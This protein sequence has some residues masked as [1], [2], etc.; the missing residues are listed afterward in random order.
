MTPVP[1][2]LF[3]RRPDPIAAEGP[4]EQGARR[5][6]AEVLLPGQLS[7]QRAGRSGR[8][9]SG[10]GELGGGR[11]AGRHSAGGRL[12]RAD[13]GRAVDA[14]RG[15]AV[16]GD[17]RR[18]CDALR[19]AAGAVGAGRSDLRDAP[20]TARGTRRRAA[21]EAARQQAGR[22]ASTAAPASAAAQA[23]AGT[24][25]FA[26]AQLVFYHHGPDHPL[27]RP[28]PADVLRKIDVSL[29]RT[30][31]GTGD[32][33]ILSTGFI[34]RRAELHR[35]R[36]RL[37]RGDKVLVFQGLGGLGKTT[38]AFQTLPLIVADED[39][40]CALW[41]REAEQ[42]ADPA[43]ALRRAAVGVLSPPVRPRLGRGRAAGRPPG[44]R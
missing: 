42:A 39:D 25:P 36:K 38:L 7:R 22:P 12:L 41:C 2:L 8:G 32:R 13:P 19:R 3:A 44:G 26:W 34:G 33:K 17:R 10:G 21:A 18:P 35:V 20:R 14:G 40:V 15:G 23:Q 6:V 16:W 5:R 1:F 37:R 9:A 30:F 11:A 24:H 27:S 4:A 28:V 43:E 31:T 29:Q